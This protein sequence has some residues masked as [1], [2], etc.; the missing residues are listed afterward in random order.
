MLGLLA[1]ALVLLLSAAACTDDSPDPRDPTS[2]WS[3]TG[4]IDTPSPT[5]PPTEPPS[6]PGLPEAAKQA[7]EDGARA[8]IE[9]YWELINYAQVTGDVKALKAAS[10]TTCKGC[11]AGIRGIRRHYQSGGTI[12]GGAHRVDHATLTE[13]TSESD[14][15]AFHSEVQVEHDGQTIMSGDG[16]EEAREPGSD[17]WDLY[18]LWVDGTRWRLDVMELK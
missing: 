1:A 13:V 8:F 17:K 18:L 6:E 9:Y 16:A 7:S 10:A 12:V 2:T 5:E 11:Q 4:T 15:Y 14:I 3:P